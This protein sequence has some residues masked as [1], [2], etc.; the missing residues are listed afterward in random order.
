MLLRYLIWRSWE[1]RHSSPSLFISPAAPG[2]GRIPVHRDGAWIDR[3]GPREGLAEEPLG[4][5]GIPPGRQQEV[6]RLAATVDRSIEVDPEPLHFHVRL[7]DS[8]R[9][10]RG[11]QMRPKALFEILRIG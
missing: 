9:A 10:I 4:G 2:I 6:D 7:F 3:V 1:N 8:P 5:R 11:M